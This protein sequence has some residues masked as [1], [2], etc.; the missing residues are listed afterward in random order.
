MRERWKN[1]RMDES[2]RAELEVRQVKEKRRRM[3]HEIRKK[4]VGK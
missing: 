2:K 4:L 3:R 1:G